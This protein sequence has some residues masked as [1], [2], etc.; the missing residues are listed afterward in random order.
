MIALENRQFEAAIPYLEQ[1]YQAESSNQATLKL[2]GLAY[3]WVGKSDPAETLF[4][5]LDS[6]G[7]LVGINTVMVELIDRKLGLQILSP[8]VALGLSAHLGRMTL[9]AFAFREHSW[10]LAR[11]DFALHGVALNVRFEGPHFALDP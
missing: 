6:R 10:R 1:A 7:E 5:Q 3:L 4:R 11:A 2:L 8:G 9:G